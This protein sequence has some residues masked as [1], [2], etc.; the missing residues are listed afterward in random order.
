MTGTSYTNPTFD[1]NSIKSEL[2]NIDKL[3]TTGAARRGFTELGFSDQDVVD[4]ISQIKSGDFHKTMPS[5]KMP[6]YYFDVYKTKYKNK[7]IYVKFQKIKDFIVVSFKEDTS[8]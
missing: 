4:A 6:A 2:D 7:N 5:D 3:R 8:I 1:L